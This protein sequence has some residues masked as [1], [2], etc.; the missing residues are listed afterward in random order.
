MLDTLTEL[1]REI[2]NHRLEVGDCI[3]E[4]LTADDRDAGREGVD[5][6]GYHWD[7][8]EAVAHFLHVGRWQHALDINEGI[9]REVL[10]EAI[11]GNTY[12]GTCEGAVEDGQ[13]T[14]QAFVA[15]ERAMDSLTMKVWEWLGDDFVEGKKGSKGFLADFRRMS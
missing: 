13:M 4:V 11:D 2:L 7:D 6:Q 1:E 8:I 10:W 15:R 5:A 12:V 14:R 3:A 9:V